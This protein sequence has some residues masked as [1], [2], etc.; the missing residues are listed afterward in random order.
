MN[1]IFLHI[2]STL[3]EGGWEIE[4]GRRQQ[5]EILK[6]SLAMCQSV[7]FMV[8][9][10][11]LFPGS[12]CWTGSVTAW[13]EVRALTYLFWNSRGR[14]F[15]GVSLKIVVIPSSEWPWGD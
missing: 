5:W 11:R 7:N 9:L 12:F 10:E 6:C 14:R 1:K 13:R 4:L 8:G 2:I 15:H 3:V